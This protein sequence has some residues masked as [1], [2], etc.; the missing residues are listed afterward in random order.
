MC[1]RLI[2]MTGL[3]I[4]TPQSLFSAEIIKVAPLLSLSLIYTVYL[5]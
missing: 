4:N 2:W 5:C 3:Q 1:V